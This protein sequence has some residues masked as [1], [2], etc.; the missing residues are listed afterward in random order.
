MG[1]WSCVVRVCEEGGMLS[2]WEWDGGG[3]DV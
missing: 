3:S 1:W 2:L